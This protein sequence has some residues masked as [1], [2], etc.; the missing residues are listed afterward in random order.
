MRFHKSLAGVIVAGALLAACSH[1]N[2]SS[3][4]TTTTQGSPAAASPAAVTTASPM[5]N[6]AAA[7]DG[8]T[9]YQTNCS[10]CHQ[11]SGQGLPGTFPP[12]AG[13]PVVVGAAARV[14]HIVKDGFTGQ[15]SVKGVMYNG[16]MPAWGQTLSNGDIA[17]VITYVRSAW[18]NSASA[19]TPSQVA[20]TH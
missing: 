4:S 12:L 5:A 18:G 1:G 17:A 9:V 8:A 20:A 3:N 15:T 10:S 16:Q 2:Q 11:A 14:I 13:N 7:S 6:G 19:V